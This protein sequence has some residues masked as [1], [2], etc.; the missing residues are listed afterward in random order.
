[1]IGSWQTRKR[2][3]KE[4]SPILGCTAV[5][6]SD[7]PHE[8]SL[9]HRF[10]GAF[11]PTEVSSVRFHQLMTVLCPSDEDFLPSCESLYSSL[12]HIPS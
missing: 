4:T 7:F 2:F 1:M 9:N 5:P 10:H 6:R 12:N 3:F 11:T 8:S